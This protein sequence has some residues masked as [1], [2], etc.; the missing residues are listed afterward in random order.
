[1][2]VKD[3]EKVNEIRNNL[4]I[5]DLERLVIAADVL[6]REGSIQER[7]VYTNFI[8]DTGYNLPRG[9]P[10]ETPVI[11]NYPDKSLTRVYI[12][13][14]GDDIRRRL[15]ILGAYVINCK[16]GK[17][18]HVSA[19]TDSLPLSNTKS[20]PDEEI[21]DKVERQLLQEFLTGEKGLIKTIQE[22]SP[23]NLDLE[24]YSE[25]DENLDSLEFPGF[26]HIYMYSKQQRDALSKSVKR[27]VGKGGGEFESL[28]TLLGM[29]EEIG[30][31]EIDQ[32]MVSIMQE[33]FKTRHLLRFIGFGI[34]QTVEQFSRKGSYRESFGDNKFSWRY[35]IP[36]KNEEIKLMYIF[37]KNLFENAVI[38]EENN[39]RIRLN[40]NEG[41][42]LTK[43]GGFYY[44]QFPF[45]HR[46]V[47]QIPLEYTWGVF[48]KLDQSWIDPS[49]FENDRE[50][51]KVRDLI[52]H[53]RNYWNFQKDEF[54]RIEKEHLKA[55]IE[56]MAEAIE[57]IEASIPEW[58]K[59]SSVPKK[60]IPIDKLGNL[61]FDDCELKIT[62]REY[63]DLEHGAKKRDL[64]REWR[65]SVKYRITEGRSAIF[66]CLKPPNP[67]NELNTILGELWA[68]SSIQEDLV[69]SESGISKDDW[70]VMTPLEGKDSLREEDIKRATDISRMPLVRVSELKNDVIKIEAPWNDWDW[71]SYYHDYLT[72]HRRFALPDNKE[73]E[74]DIEIQ[75][76]EFFILDPA[77]DDISSYH[78]SRALQQSDD[79]QILSWLNG[80]LTGNLKS[81]DMKIDEEITIQDIDYFINKLFVDADCI[82]NKPNKEQMEF[83]RDINK[84]VVVVQGPPGT[85][86]TS[87]TTTPAILSRV[88]A[89]EQIGKN[90]SGAI[91]ALSHDA[92]DEL[93]NKVK[94][95]V[96]DIQ[97]EN[98]FKNLKLVRV[99]PGGLPE[100]IKD[101][102]ERD[103]DQ[104]IEYIGYHEKGGKERLKTLAKNYLINQSEESNSRHFLLFGPPLSIRG[105]INEI[106]SLIKE[107]DGGSDDSDNQEEDYYGVWN[108][109]EDDGKSNLFD[110]TVVD[111]ASMMDLPLMILAGAFLKDTGQILL[112]GDHRQM[113]PIQ[114]HGWEDEDRKTIEE[115]I[116]F[117]S[118]LNY[119]RFLKGEI[120]DMEYIERDSPKLDENINQ[121]E[122][123]KATLPIYRLK[124]SFRLPD[125]VAGLLTEFFYKEDG[126]NLRGVDQRRKIPNKQP[127]TEKD[128]IK[129]VL[130]PNK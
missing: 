112:A 18:K 29:R 89:Y 17:S 77:L 114:A 52:F 57:H 38:F 83:I 127:N 62:S 3:E 103:E 6:S 120:E 64:Q 74:T 59:D 75:E 36:E 106:A 26:V 31:R 1:M 2:S 20:T 53:F 121:D 48:D 50:L 23:K 118:A 110:L 67:K 98:A 46:Y 7:P 72:Y 37:D 104:I 85:G 92:V 47:D 30:E 5:K 94:Q 25:W 10:E 8:P 97:L 78:C 91:S 90:F 102:G 84:H 124:N 60:A 115:T 81:D 19:I 130:D 70:V 93:F 56:K 82:D 71:S 68:P 125:E 65:Q 16:T 51:E 129:E 113:Q 21:K 14:Q 63:L 54:I 99:R 96:K 69:F 87:Y 126:I 95:V 15:N 109:L 9:D 108:L 35:K 128:A 116:P 123:E 88:Y 22:V 49:H 117:L 111:E 44:S 13:L 27:H 32:D 41:K 79:N 61:S 55:L 119:I 76:G 80:L 39:G 4:R 43:I 12:Y 86:K 100:N 24:N 122:Q 42:E 73:N 45:D 40:L 11:E 66:K 105:A 28:R 101:Y 107:D 33:E 58:L 34:V